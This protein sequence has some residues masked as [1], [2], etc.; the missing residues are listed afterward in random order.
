MQEQITLIQS[1]AKR[2]DQ[3]IDRFLQC[4]PITHRVSDLN[5]IFAPLCWIR[6]VFERG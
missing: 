1:L 3:E 2:L 6:T 4:N 5:T